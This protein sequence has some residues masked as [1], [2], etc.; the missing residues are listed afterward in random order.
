MK[1]HAFTLIELLVVVLI[2]GILAAVALPQYEKAVKKA[3]FMELITIGDAI[4]KAQEVYYLTNNAYASSQDELDIQVPLPP[5]IGMYLSN[6]S[7]CFISLTSA[8]IPNLQ[9]LFYLDHHTL[10]GYRGRRA[11]RVTNNDEKLKQI[12]RSITGHD[13][14]GSDNYWVSIF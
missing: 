1:N 2:I 8:K 9:Y 4:H 14:G 13:I 7:D 5:H 12:C 3:H 6:Q 10:A 11:C